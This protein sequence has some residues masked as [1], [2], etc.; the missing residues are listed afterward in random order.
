MEGLKS[1][2]VV[3]T[4]IDLG[5]DYEAVNHEGFVMSNQYGAFKLV[6]RQKFSFYN[7]TLPKQW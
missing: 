4:I 5:V 6:K 7:F 2:E 1:V 3:D